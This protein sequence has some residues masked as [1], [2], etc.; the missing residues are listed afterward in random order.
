MSESL[1]PCWTFRTRRGDFN[2]ILADHG[3]FVA[4]FRGEPVLGNY[5]TA[6][7]AAGDVHHYFSDAAAV[8]HRAMGGLRS[9]FK[10]EFRTPG[11]FRPLLSRNRPDS[12]RRFPNFRMP[13]RA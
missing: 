8:G 3:A 1:R 6:D 13:F 2:I 4:A 7:L 9:R 5:A 11:E 12:A 10:A